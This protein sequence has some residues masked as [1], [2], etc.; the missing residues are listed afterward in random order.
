MNL[1]SNDFF[2]SWHFFGREWDYGKYFGNRKNYRTF[3][4]TSNEDKSYDADVLDFNYAYFNLLP[5]DPVY[6]MELSDDL[7]SEN[8]AAQILNENLKPA[9]SKDDIKKGRRFYQK[10][11]TDQGRVV[12]II[13]RL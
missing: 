11:D 5:T 1:L 13:V 9:E 2:Q 12:N 7:A 3:G 10:L 6:V 4:S 8:F